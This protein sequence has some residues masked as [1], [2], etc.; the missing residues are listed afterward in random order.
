MMDEY[1]ENEVCMNCYSVM[2]YYIS[3][4]I[5]G[6]E[7]V[8]LLCESCSFGLY[9]CR[10]CRHI[11]SHLE[12]TNYRQMVYTGRPNTFFDEFIFCWECS[13]TA[14]LQEDDTDTETETDVED[15][16]DLE[17]LPLGTETQPLE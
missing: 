1:F 17:Q 14:D 6:H 15:M 4:D 2:D 7:N 8:L 11:V 10:R 16:D 13:Q 12:N 9:Q 5:P 3:F